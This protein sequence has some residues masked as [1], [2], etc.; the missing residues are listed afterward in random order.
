MKNDI[1]SYDIVCLASAALIITL[2][3]GVINYIK[4][5][6]KREGKREVQNEAVVKGKAEF[7]VDTNRTVTFRWKN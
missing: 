2:M 3:F 4:N 1:T 5:E 6:G 7:L